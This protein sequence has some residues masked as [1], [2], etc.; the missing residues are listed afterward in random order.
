MPE[1]RLFRRGDRQQLTDLVNA[2]LGAVAPGWAI[3][4]AALLAS[5]ES[6]PTQYVTDPWVRDRRTLVSVVDGRVV[7]ALHLRRYGIE[8]DVSDDYRNAGEIAWF[9]FWPDRPDAAADLLRAG[10][11]LLAQDG[12]AHVFADGDLPTP[13]SYGVPDSWPH[14]AAALS[15]AGFEADPACTEVVLSKDLG[16]HASS[17]D[18]DSHRLTRAVGIHGTR[19][20][21][22]T[23]GAPSGYIEVVENLTR[24]GTLMAL[25]GWAEIAELDLA[26]PTDETVAEVLLEAAIRWL[27]QAGSRHV[28]ASAAADDHAD[29]T[30]LHRRGWRT[31]TVVQRGW[32]LP[33]E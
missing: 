9:V 20:T 15:A 7:G 23:D 29:L 4:S 28:L 17:A 14:V 6:D 11:V 25:S 18:L 26:A 33:I 22:A 13:V 10:L 31:L 24:G 19:F 27:V 21:A 8:R 1:I 5:L 32:R 12:V 30:R 16:A 2:H 3:S